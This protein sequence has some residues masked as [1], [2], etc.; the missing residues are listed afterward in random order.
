MFGS[1]GAGGEG[2]ALDA[3]EPR[4]VDFGSVINQVGSGSGTLRHFLKAFRVRAVVRTHHQDQV[5]PLGKDLDGGLAVLGGVADVIARGGDQARKAP[6]E[7][8]DDHVSVIDTQSRLCDHGDTVGVCDFDPLGLLH[9]SDQLSSVRDFAHSADDLFMTFVSNKDDGTAF[10]GEPDRLQVN[11]GDQRAR[12]VND[13]QAFRSGLRSDLR[14][15]PVGAEN[16]DGAVGDL[17]DFFDEDDALGDERIDDV[18]VVYDL[19]PY[20]DRARV[21]VQCQVHD[22]NGAVHTGA[23]SPRPREQDFAWLHRIG[24]PT[25]LLVLGANVD[26]GHALGCPRHRLLMSAI[27]RSPFADMPNPHVCATQCFVSTPS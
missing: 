25:Q 15:H 5:R 20:V 24:S 16:G 14:R 12:G 23:E 18:L 22:F 6:P 3:L 17:V 2:H 11:F 13:G 26:E 10:S 19:L 21:Q 7:R 1:G 4:W 9:G 8:V 27:Q